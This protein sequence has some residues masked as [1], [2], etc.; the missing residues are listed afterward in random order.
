MKKILSILLVLGVMSSCTNDFTDLNTDTK[1][2]TEVP[3]EPLFTN[4]MRNLV[5][6]M[7]SISVNRNVFR[8][9]SQYWAQTT[10]PEESQ[11][12][13]V[14]RNIP[15]NMW[16]TYYKDVL[17][18]LSESKTIIDATTYP[19]EIP[20]SV[21]TNKLAIIEVMTIYTYSVLVDTYGDVPYTQALDITNET[22][23]YD[24]AKT[25]YYDLISRLDAAIASLDET[26]YGFA[27]GEDL[28]YGGDMSGWAKFSNSLKLRLA[29]RI[30]DSD[31]GKASTMVAAVSGKVLASNADNFSMTYYN[32]SPNT[33]PIYSGL[34]LSG[35]FDFV[36]SN[37][38]IDKM[39]ADNDPRRSKWFN[40]VGG[41]YI[42][43][44]YGDANSYK[45]FS[46][47]GNA[48]SPTPLTNPELSGTLMNYAEVEFMLAEAK[49]R[50][51]TVNG[52]AEEH[53]NAGIEASI[54]E[55]GGTAA[56]YTA[57]IAEPTVAYATAAG[58]YKQKIGIQQ[59]RALFNQGFDG[60][61]TW[62]KFDFTGMNA[63]PGMT[64]GDI[65]T[66][67]IYPT[68][69]HS[70]NG[71]NWAAAAAKYDSDSKTAKVFW[72]VN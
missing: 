39:N 17:K 64:L 41:A 18:D 3:G 40:Q 9:Y 30:A 11:Y 10:Y 23:V 25:V 12:N 24:D 15:D 22:P 49:E 27:S 52:T 36:G 8:L 61:C 7:Q 72:D 28:V 60:W 54:L 71:S 32:A 26:T 20:A 67:F 5:D 2:P 38:L 6:Q 65:P 29:M 14:T 56:D 47:M 48:T 66:R 58:T 35:R 34:I 63:V 70:L 46:N 13:M 1:N 33:S 37:T 69:E 43:G 4:A 55:W 68:N 31:N 57:Y 19:P 45:L 59:W 21:K 44:V 51:Y 16:S 50:G 62:R 53:Y 42:G